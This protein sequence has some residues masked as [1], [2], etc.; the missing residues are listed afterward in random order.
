MPIQGVEPEKNLAL[1]I[2]EPIGLTAHVTGT[3]NERMLHP[4]RELWPERRSILVSTERR[5]S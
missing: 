5:H 1:L 4:K 3:V 2:I